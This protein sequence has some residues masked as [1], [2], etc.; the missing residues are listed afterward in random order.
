MFGDTNM[1]VEQVREFYK[2][3]NNSQLSKKIN[4]G[5]ST[6]H[7]WEANGIPPSA[8]AV[9]EILSKGKLKADKQALT[10]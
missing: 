3:E 1:N 8:Q 2:V 5:R 7:G 9:L 4:K 6:I 10:A